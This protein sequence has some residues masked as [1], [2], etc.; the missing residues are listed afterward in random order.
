[1]AMRRGLVPA[2]T[3][4]LTGCMSSAPVSYDL[5]ALRIADGA[6]SSHAQLVIAEPLAIQA[7]DSQQILV[8]SDGNRLSYLSG[9]QWADRLPQIVQARLVQSFENS[10]HL[11]HVARPGDRIVPDYQ[12]NSEIRA[13]EFDAAA[14]DVKVEI[15]GK[16]INDRSG[17]IAASQVFSAHVAQ[18]S[19]APEAVAR[20]L[21]EALSTVMKQMLVWAAKTI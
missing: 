8:R 19:A 12:L 15:E 20:S 1:M 9:A 16:L 3:M 21:D 6:R 5:T 10:H 13:F 4:M 17:R 11:S 14:G 18:T 7:L 2:L